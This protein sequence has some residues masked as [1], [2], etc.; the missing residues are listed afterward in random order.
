MAE[1]EWKEELFNIEN[2]LQSWRKYIVENA[3]WYAELSD[4]VKASSGF[5]ENLA[6]KMNQTISKILSEPPTAEQI[7]QIEALQKKENRKIDFSCK[8]EAAFILNKFG[9]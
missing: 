6:L 2:F 3:K 1:I 7:E 8:A 5:H 9:S 4:D